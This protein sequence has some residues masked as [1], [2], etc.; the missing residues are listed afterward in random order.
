MGE[1]GELVSEPVVFEVIA[2]RA[3]L[4]TVVNGRGKGS[5]NIQTG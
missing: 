1:Y 2:V 5:I 3:S 4:S